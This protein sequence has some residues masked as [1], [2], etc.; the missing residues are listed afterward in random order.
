MNDLPME[1]IQTVVFEDFYQLPPVPN[2]FLGDS[3]NYAS[4]FPI[5]P[6]LCPHKVVLTQLQRQNDRQLIS[7]I[8]ETA[9]GCPTTETLQF[10]G[11]LSS[12]DPLRY[13]CLHLGQMY[14][15]L[16]V[17]RSYMVR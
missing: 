9:R 4:Q 7:T 10:L 2:H 1:G 8:H 14:T 13:I 3:G 16:M 11:T 17:K 15:L 12:E 5:W 6:V